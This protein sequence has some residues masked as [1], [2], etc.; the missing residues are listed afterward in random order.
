MFDVFLDIG[1]LFVKETLH[2]IA[3]ARIAD[4]MGAVGGLG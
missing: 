1:S 2:G 3:K 4:K